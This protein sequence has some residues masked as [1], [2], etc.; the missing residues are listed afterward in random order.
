MARFLVTCKE[1]K[2]TK[3]IQGI[4]SMPCLETF[5]RIRERMR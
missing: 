3:N 4:A 1:I 5:V 2:V